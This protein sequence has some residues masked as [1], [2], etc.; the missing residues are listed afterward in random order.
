MY[1]SI[2]DA[3]YTIGST[4]ILVLAL[5][6]IVMAVFKKLSRRFAKGVA[7]IIL[8]TV[9][10]A[11]VFP[12]VARTELRDRLTQEVISTT[13]ERPVDNSAV[14]SA[15]KDITYAEG[16][17]SHPLERFGFELQTA[18]DVIYL[19]LA[20]DSIDSKAYWVYFPKYRTGDANEIGKIQL[21]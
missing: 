21:K 13:S 10:T 1:L 15:L 6:T 14:I 9:A 12:N 2:L 18:K 16:R 19:E 3:M 11:Y 20:R 5:I 17:K 8:I 4:S 7:S